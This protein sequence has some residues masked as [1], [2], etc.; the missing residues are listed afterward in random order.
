MRPATGYEL[1]Q[2]IAK[3]IKGYSPDAWQGLEA[4]QIVEAML[5]FW[6]L[7]EESTPIRVYDGVKWIS[8]GGETIALWKEM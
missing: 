1:L 6:S 5:F 2:R 3:D 8:D 7:D 4:G